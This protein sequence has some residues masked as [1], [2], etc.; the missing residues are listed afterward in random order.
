MSQR[1]FKL[2]SYDDIPV[3][4]TGGM[5]FIGSNLAVAL[6]RRGARVTV[7]DAQVPG[8]GGNPANLEEVRDQIHLVRCDLQDADQMRELIPKQRIIFNLAGEISHISSMTNPL[9]DLAINCAAQL[10]FLNL[11]RLIN[12]RATI[13]YASSRQVYGVPQY[14]PVDENHPVSP[15]DFNG[16][17]KH[18]TEGYHFLLRNQFQMHT[19]CLRL[20]NIY[21]PRQAIYQDCRGFIDAF[22]RMAL[23]LRPIEIFG[24]GKQLRGM[25]YVDDAV[26]AFLKAGLSADDAAPVYNVGAPQPIALIEIAETLMRLTGG[27]APIFR[28]FPQERLSI[29]VGS[30]HT[31]SEKF[32]RDYG[33]YPQIGIEEGLRNTIQFFRERGN[34][35][36]ASS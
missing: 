28:P 34:V 7:V 23:E 29:D 10:Q 2:Q 6:V 15:V 18:A 32:R 14:T 4:V 8:C 9:R 26:D 27:P 24:D 17:H 5:G 3:L 19:I 1:K 30:F 22:V 35:S 21:G 20:G 16:V 25:V 33:W 31:S 13:I 11:C 36:S 12:Q